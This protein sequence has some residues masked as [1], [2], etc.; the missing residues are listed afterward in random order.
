MPLSHLK[1]PS[2]LVLSSIWFITKISNSRLTNVFSWFVE[3]G[4]KQHP[5]K[6]FGCLVREVSFNLEQ[7]LTCP[8]MLLIYCKNQL[9]CTSECCIFCKFSPLSSVIYLVPSSSTFPIVRSLCSRFDSI[10]I[11]LWFFFLPKPF[12]VLCA[13][14]HITMKGDNV[15]LPHF[16]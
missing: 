13:S 3:L 16:Q 8:T 10:L 12:M 11:L 9:S 6:G 7:S 14:Y 1:N 15:W 5:H 2:Y 4:S